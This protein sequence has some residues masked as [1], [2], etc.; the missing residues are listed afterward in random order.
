MANA[1]THP[2][3]ITVGSQC[4]KALMGY[5]AK[6]ATLDKN[7]NAVVISAGQPVRGDPRFLGTQTLTRDGSK[8]DHN[9][10]RGVDNASIARGFNVS[11]TADTTAA[12]HYIRGVMT[13]RQTIGGQTLDT[14]QETLGVF[15]FGWSTQVP[16]F[17]QV[18]LN[19]VNY[20]GLVCKQA[21][22]RQFTWT[23]T[24]LKSEASIE[25]L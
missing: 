3:E 9:G 13:V 16:H 1:Q 21:N 5:S 7:G 20:V 12:D 6:T 10:Q 25:G 23:L 15:S 8:K 14:R 24:S 19:S 4:M 22:Y 17:L 18:R 11:L 2:I